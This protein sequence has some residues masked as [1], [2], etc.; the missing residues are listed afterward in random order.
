[1]RIACGQEAMGAVLQW[2]M[3][4]QD[5]RTFYSGELMIYNFEC[6]TKEFENNWFKS[7]YPRHIMCWFADS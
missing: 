5:L 6:W 3:R 7:E 2:R 4:R 1:M